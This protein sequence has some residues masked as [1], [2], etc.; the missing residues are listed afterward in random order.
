MKLAKALFLLALL[1]GGPSFAQQPPPAPAVGVVAATKQ[2]ITQS[3]EYIGRV[4]AIERV[5]LVARIVAFLDEVMFEEG[6]EVKKGDLLYRLEQG[7]YKAEVQAREAAVAQFKAQLQNATLA[8]QRAQSLLRTSAGQQ[9]SVDTA[10]ANAEALKAQVLGAE[11]QL[12][13]ARIALGYTE[14]RSPIDGKIGRTSTTA[15]NFVGPN[16]G[17]LVS[18]VSQDPMYVLFQV[19]TRTVVEM[20]N[21]RV[22][23]PG[24]LVIRLRLPDGSM[25]PHP[26]KLDFIDN[27]VTG[28]TDT[29]TLRAV[30]PNPRMLDLPQGARQ[31]VDGQLVTAIAQEAEPVEALVVPRAAVLTDQA[32]DFVFV[33]G[34]DNKAMQRRVKLGQST[35]AIAAIVDGLKEGENVVVDG[36]QRVRPGIVVTPGPAQPRPGP[37]AAAP[38]P[39][40]N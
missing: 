38:A 3:A 36:I 18:V 7:S 19:S 16:T 13:V 4:Q 33:V 15:G 10:L 39:P 25:Y 6:T 37:P 14:I 2:P 35:P 9:S 40:R 21:K 34:A 32:G 12:Q 8:L 23:K 11:A 26:G 31:L 20:Q 29:M 24:T 28:N 5:N 22:D 1:A 30:M 27:S 17:V